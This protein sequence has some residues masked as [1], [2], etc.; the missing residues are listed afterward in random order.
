MKVENLLVYI[1]CI[2]DYQNI[3]AI[4]FFTFY[5]LLLLLLRLEEKEWFIYIY[6]N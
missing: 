3:A 5:L 1:L 2:I 4:T 6:Q